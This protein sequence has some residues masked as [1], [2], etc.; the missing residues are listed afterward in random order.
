MLDNNDNKKPKSCIKT[1]A[2]PTLQFDKKNSP[3]KINPPAPSMNFSEYDVTT[4]SPTQ[5]Y[6]IELLV[7]LGTFGWQVVQVSETI[8]LIHRLDVVG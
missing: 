8:L 4:P 1:A 6:G 2:T 3:Q 5:Q 7:G